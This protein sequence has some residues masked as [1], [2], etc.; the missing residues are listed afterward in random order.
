VYHLQ[1]IKHVVLVDPHTAGISGDM[2]L[3]ALIDL[4]ANFNK[5]RKVTSTACKFLA[6]CKKIEINIDDVLKRGIRAKRVSVEAYEEFSHRTGRELRDAVERCLE[7]TAV[8]D[9]AKKFAF[10]SLSTILSAEAKVHSS[11]VDDVELHE[12]GS[13]DTVVDIVGVAVALD[14]L[15]LFNNTTVYSLP[16]T[17]GYG[18]IEVSHGL[19]S[20]PT[21]VTLE[22]LRAKKF[23]FESGYIKGELA[24]PT[25]ISLLANLAKPVLNYPAFQVSKVGLGAGRFDFKEIPNILRIAL[26][27]PFG[28]AFFKDEICVIETNLDDV[29]GEVVGHLIERL[30]KEGAKDASAIPALGK[31]GRSSILVKI[32]AD[33]ADVDHLVKIVF[34]ETGTLGIRTYNCNRFILPRETLKVQIE[35]NRKKHGLK[36][37]VAKDTTGRIIQVKPEYEDAKKIALKT[38]VSLRKILNDAQRRAEDII[39]SR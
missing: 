12:I 10:D 17:V 6:G 37:K 31:K 1:D 7:N 2:F 23:P 33:K 18:K 5:V 39:F 11:T 32:I 8:S 27:S 4:G 34:D 22:I 16:I 29:S 28:T 38:G 30:M 19:L 21:P 9:Y 26:G 13:V 15:K 35:I 3:G 20:I 14:D 24:T 36:V 25:G